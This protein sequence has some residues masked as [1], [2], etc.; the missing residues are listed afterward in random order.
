ML[1]SSGAIGVGLRRMGLKE[2]GKGLSQ[3]QVST[4]P[5]IDISLP[6]SSIGRENDLGSLCDHLTESIF[7]AGARGYWSRTTHSSMG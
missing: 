5:R 3:K 4:I 1:V 7:F 6:S 2:R